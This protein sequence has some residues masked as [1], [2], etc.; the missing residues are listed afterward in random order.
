VEA[1][2]FTDAEWAAVSEAAR[3]VVNASL[4]ED[5]VLHASNVAELRDVLAELRAQYGDHPVLLETEADFTSYDSERL[6]LYRR[7]V[8]IASA[9]QFPT[10]S[11]RLSLAR[12]LIGMGL[13]TPARTELLAC[14]GEA[15]AG[16]ESERD[17]WSELI[18]Q[19]RS[20]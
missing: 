14:E 10:L 15:R 2:P 16:D 19:A 9:H 6:A 5:E 4:A 13:T 8:R 18:A 20:V 7:A 3:L 1:F 17:K 11:I 12:L